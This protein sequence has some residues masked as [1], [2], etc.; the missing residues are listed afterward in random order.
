MTQGSVTNNLSEIADLQKLINSSKAAAEH[1]TDFKPP[2]YNIWTAS[3]RAEQPAESQAPM[4]SCAGDRGYG[5]HQAQP[6][7][8]YAAK[9]SVG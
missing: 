9:A 5:H 2:I 7:Y 8:E 4:Q 3:N 1:S 6:P